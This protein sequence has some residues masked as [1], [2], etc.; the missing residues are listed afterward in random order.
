MET[1]VRA[2][3]AKDET[4][5]RVINALESEVWP[6]TLSK[7]KCIAE[8]LSVLNGIVMKRGCAVIPEL[9]RKRALDI[10]H[11]GHPLAAKLKSILR[12]RVWWPGMTVDA[13]QWVEG[14]QACATTGKPAKPTPM[15]RSFA[16]KAAWQT[17]ALNFNGPYAK[18]GG[19]LILVVVD[20]RSRY[21]FAKPI[22]STG[23]EHVKNYLDRVFEIE[24][25]P[26]N[27]KTD[28]G[29]P[30]NSE[31]YKKY[32]R[33]RGINAIFSTPFFPQQNGLVEGYMKLVN[34]AIAT[35]IS[36]GTNYVKELQA[37]VE[38]HNAA[39]H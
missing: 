8:D 18:L 30:F 3:T 23:L 39:A 4:L 29:P 22:R 35:A 16:P 2:A 1:E 15:T 32:C 37:A 28:N 17:I 31:D 38:A 11:T 21:L 26:Q 9:L 6:K 12:E 14:C 19:I 34:K 20:Y 24:G 25:Y 33:E 13:E 27:I 5:Q 36:T 10:A 7:F